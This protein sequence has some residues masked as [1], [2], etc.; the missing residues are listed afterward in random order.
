[1]LT[2]ENKALCK[3][4]RL[5]ITYR[6]KSRQSS[7]SAAVSCSPIP[8]N[9]CSESQMLTDICSGL[10]SPGRNPELWDLQLTYTGWY[11]CHSP[12]QRERPLL[13]NLNVSSG[14]EEEDKITN[15]WCEQMYL[16]KKETLLISISLGVCIFR[17]TPS[18][19]SRACLQKH[20]LYSER[21]DQAYI[22]RYPRKIVSLPTSTFFLKINTCVC[23]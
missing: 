17:E 21:L 4:H 9:W 12:S 16:K 13:C 8:T 18:L 1:M 3:R 19:A 14:K 15:L 5:F 23:I 22:L 7:I 6:K 20:L 10:A 11:T 2:R